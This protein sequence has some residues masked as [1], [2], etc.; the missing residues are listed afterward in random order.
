[1][2]SAHPEPANQTKGTTP[3]QPSDSSW[4]F[5][6]S[7]LLG[8][9]GAL[10]GVAVCCRSRRAR[11]P[12]KYVKIMV[13]DFWQSISQTFSDVRHALDGYS[14][15]HIH[16]WIE[17][18]ELRTRLR[19]MDGATDDSVPSLNG[20][21]AVTS[22]QTDQEA[23]TSA[24]PTPPDSMDITSDPEETEEKSRKLSAERKESEDI[25]K[26]GVVQQTKRYRSRYEQQA[27]GA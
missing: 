19:Q 13:L 11:A 1:M 21:T 9:F 12:L 15:P 7:A 24:T 20:E 16:E 2:A 5:I 23:D 18:V 8:I 10:A 14:S 3:S 27:S 22:P 17:D 6:G 25:A 4:I 26:K